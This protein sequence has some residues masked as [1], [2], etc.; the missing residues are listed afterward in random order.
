MDINIVNII[1]EAYSINLVINNNVLY[2]NKN[3]INI[4]I[5]FNDELTIFESNNNNIESDILCILLKNKQFNNYIMWLEFICQISNEIKNYCICCGGKLDYSS[6]I[7]TTC[8]SDICKYKYEEILIDN[9]VHDFIIKNKTAPYIL[10]ELSKITFNNNKELFDPFPPYFLNEKVNNVKRGTVAKLQLNPNTFNEY[11]EKK[12]YKRLNNV[13][14]F[15]DLNYLINNI[16]ETP[17]DKLIKEK[18]GNDVYYFLRFIFKSCKYD[19]TTINDELTIYKIISNEHDEQEFQ[20]QVSINNNTTCLLYHGSNNARWY[21]IIRN[22]LINASGT[23]MMANGASYGYGIYM[24]D[25]YKFALNYSLKNHSANQLIVGVY[26]VVGEENKYKKDKS[27]YVIPDTKDCIL[28]YLIFGNRTINEQSIITDL[29]LHKNNYNIKPKIHKKLLREF[30]ILQKNEIYDVSL[31]NNNMF[32]WIVTHN[33]ITLNIKFPNTYPFD[34]PF[35]YIKSPI[36]TESSKYITNKG[37]LCFEFLTT[38]YW[39]PII[40]IENLIIQIYV[41]IIYNAEIKE[42]KENNYN[43]A[44]ESFKTL[45]IGNGWI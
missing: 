40:S 2:V 16:Y 43:D 30:S 25:S 8:G 7:F 11:Q 34:P 15:F 31:V 26:E 3:D 42:Y 19:I 41:L 23:N 12:N 29:N 24:S 14:N 38:K 6:D 10:F 4:N 17:S 28:R 37:A 44:I 5:K 13:I 32:D 22:G 9:Y 33:N 1:A 35:I 20:K 21:S 36:F 39:I 18:Y 45:T 27:I